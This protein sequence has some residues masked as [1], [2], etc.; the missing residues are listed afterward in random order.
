MYNIQKNYPI[1]LKNSVFALPLL[2]VMTLSPNSEESSFENLILTTPNSKN[3]QKSRA[4][5]AK[6]GNPSR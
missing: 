2:E 4:Q 6:D 1:L 5:G 3:E